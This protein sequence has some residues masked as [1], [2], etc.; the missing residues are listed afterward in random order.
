MN[1]GILL[2]SQNRNIISADTA[3]MLIQQGYNIYLSNKVEKIYFAESSSI[4]SYSLKAN[5]LDNYK[6]IITYIK[7]RITESSK[8]TEEDYNDIYKKIDYKIKLLY[9]EKEI[10]QYEKIR[11]LSFN[12]LKKISSYEY[13]K[14]GVFLVQSNE[15]IIKN[16]ELITCFDLDKDDIQYI[17]KKNIVLC[18]ANPLNNYSKIKKLSKNETSLLAIEY[19]KDN[20]SNYPV[21]KAISLA[22][23]NIGFNII[24]LLLNR[25]GNLTG[26]YLFSK[27]NKVTI[28]GYG[29]IGKTLADLF[30]HFNY[31]V[32]VFEKD[33]FDYST[34]NNRIIFNMSSNKNKLE[35]TIINSDIVI[36]TIFNNYQIC[37]KIVDKSI[38]EKINKKIIFF[39]FTINQGGTFEG[40][41]RT[42][43]EDTFNQ[44]YNNSPYN[45]NVIQVGIEDLL[46]F[47]GYDLTQ[48]ISNSIYSFIIEIIENK[49]YLNKNK[50]IEE[51]I[52]IY[53]GDI[54][55]LDY[56][57]LE[58]NNSDNSIIDPSDFIP[59]INT[60]NDNLNNL[61]AGATSYDELRLGKKTNSN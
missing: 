19:L 51:S 52:V 1:I 43:F 54:I 36:S 48:S 31:E 61:L 32:N 25:K 44:L 39:D 35:E 7:K 53:K 50:K 56:I 18:Y 55:D 5:E 12:Y 10:T 9:K 14:N 40:I 20:N 13:I 33:D 29:N 58:D 26:N 49:N 23:S 6:K 24:N 3:Y 16:C 4:K 30:L 28:L 60:K 17:T 45:K 46:K 21:K 22:C 47:S 38:I 41:S 8:F 57:D 34:I 11:D 37:P 59:N 27:K 2:D 15:I 42:Q